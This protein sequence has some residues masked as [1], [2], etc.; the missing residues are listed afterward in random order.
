MSAERSKVRPIASGDVSMVEAL[1]L[2]VFWTS[3]VIW[4]LSFADPKAYV[5]LLNLDCVSV[6]YRFLLGLVG[7]P[8]L[9]TLYPLMKRLINWPSV[10]LGT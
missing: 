3:V 4:S 10:F 6:G 5:V 8:V 9:C 7:I 1:V 2:L